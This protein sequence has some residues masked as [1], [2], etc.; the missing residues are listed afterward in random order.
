MG[1]T[2]LVI[3]YF[4]ELCEAETDLTEVMEPAV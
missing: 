1:I 2:A 3:E 4:C